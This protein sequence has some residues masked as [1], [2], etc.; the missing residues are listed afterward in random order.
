MRAVRAG[1]KA[2]WVMGMVERAGRCGQE[3]LGGTLA[4][5]SMVRSLDR[6]GQ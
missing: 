2:G 6:V 5:T 4:E 3:Q 1:R